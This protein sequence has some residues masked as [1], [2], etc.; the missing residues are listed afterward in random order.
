[1]H[2]FYTLILDELKI[3]RG[4]VHKGRLHNFRNFSPLPCAGPIL[5]EF[6][7]SSRIRSSDPRT[8]PTPLPFVSSDMS[9]MKKITNTRE[10]KMISGS[11]HLVNFAC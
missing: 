3:L 7:T 8:P 2:L 11:K 1:M 6:Q 4:V 10:Q 9:S 5:S